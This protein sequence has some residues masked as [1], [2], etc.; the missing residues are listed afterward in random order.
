MDTIKMIMDTTYKYNYWQY[1][2]MIMD[3]INNNYWHYKYNY[4]QYN[5]NY[6]HYKYNY[7]HYNYN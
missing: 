6:R 7:G 3:T 4:G 1:I 2:I 5:H